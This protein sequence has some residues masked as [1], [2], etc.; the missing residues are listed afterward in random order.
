MFTHMSS[1]HCGTENPGQ[2]NQAR[3]RNE[4]HETQK[5]NNIK[6]S[7]FTCHAIIHRKL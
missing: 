5:G 4:R 3:K 1:I 6:L 2:T 7:L